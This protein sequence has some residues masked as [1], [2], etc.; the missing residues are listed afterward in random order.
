MRR[1]T[2]IKWDWKMSRKD[3]INMIF[4][5]GLSN[6]WLE[7]LSEEERHLVLETYKPLSVSFGTSSD[8]DTSTSGGVYSGSDLSFLT[9]LATWFDQP[10]KRAFAIKILC[11][12]ES[13]INDSSKPIDVHLFYGIKIKILYKERDS[14]PTAF[15]EVL[16]ACRNQ[17]NYART[18]IP[19]FRA[20]VC[21]E[22]PS[23]PGY[24]QLSI[25]MEKQ[26]KYAEVIELCK[27]AK[28]DGWSGDWQKRIERCEKKSV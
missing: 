25:I 16:D 24:K 19:Y 11:K 22:L 26:K 7:D 10:K 3:T 12:A 15:Q 4:A 27:A 2:A 13:L 14:A 9:S 28:R 1:Y 5:M 21:P 6:W 23:H 17:I 18:V 8:N 20:T